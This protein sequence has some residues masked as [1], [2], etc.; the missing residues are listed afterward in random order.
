MELLFDGVEYW[1][2]DVT[3]RGLP[4][5]PYWL[6]IN[7]PAAPTMKREVEEDRGSSSIVPHHT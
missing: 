6:K 7:N 2:N 3:S 4:R 1:T 5:S